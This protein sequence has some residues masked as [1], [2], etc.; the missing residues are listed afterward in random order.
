M[1]TRP[2]IV[3]PILTQPEFLQFEEKYV[4]KVIS[5]PGNRTG[6]AGLLGFRSITACGLLAGGRA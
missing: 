5:D 6:V 1:K 2:I 3:I 4:T